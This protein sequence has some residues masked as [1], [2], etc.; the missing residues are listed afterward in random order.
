MIQSSYATD[1]VGNPQAGY[2]TLAEAAELLGCTTVEVFQ[3][4]RARQLPAVCTPRTGLVIAED[5]LQLTG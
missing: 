3:R 1:L 4:V 5:D 2:L